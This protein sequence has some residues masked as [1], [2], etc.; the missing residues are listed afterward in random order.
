MSEDQYTLKTD[1]PKNPSDVINAIVEKAG[2]TGVEGVSIYSPSYYGK[3]ADLHYL[4]VRRIQPLDPSAI[5]IPE[6]SGNGTIKL[7]EVRLPPESVTNQRSMG[8]NP[9]EMVFSEFL[10]IVDRGWTRAV[11][12]ETIKGALAA[13]NG[14]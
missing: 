1:L 5:D 12:P 3:P 4:A 11:T 13:L 8:K 14:K 7:L 2:L 9:K 10:V 6:L